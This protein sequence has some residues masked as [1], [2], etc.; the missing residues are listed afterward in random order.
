MDARDEPLVYN[1]P[2]ISELGVVAY[3]GIPLLTAEGCALGSFCVIDS[4]P[5]A[6]TKHEFEILEDLA[7]SA[8]TAIELR[9]RFGHW[10]NLGAAFGGDAWWK[11]RGLQCRH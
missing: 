6:W 9:G 3:A 1:N 5:R 7:A 10:L 2:A 4:K 11:R 8:V